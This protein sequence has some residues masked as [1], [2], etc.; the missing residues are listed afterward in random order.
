MSTNKLGK[1]K[2]REKGGW[3]LQ[4]CPS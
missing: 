2:K 4:S 3:N 1:N